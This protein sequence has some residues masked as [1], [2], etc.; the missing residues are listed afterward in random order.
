LPRW[1]HVPHRHTLPRGQVQWCWVGNLLQLQCGVLWLQLWADHLLLHGPVPSWD[2]WCGAWT[3]GAVVFRWLQSGVCVC[4]REH[5]RHSGALPSRVLQPWSRVCVHALCR[6]LV[7][8][9]VGG[10]L[11]VVQWKL[12]RGVRLRCGVHQQHRCPVLCRPVQLRGRWCVHCVPA[13]V[14]W[15]HPWP[16][17]LCMLWTVSGGHLWRKRRAHC[18]DVQWELHR[19]VCVRR[20]V[21]QCHRCHLPCREVQPRSIGCVH[22]LCTRSVRRHPGTGHR[23]VYSPVLARALRRACR[24]GIR[25]L[26]GSVLCRVCMPR[27]VADTHGHRV[28]CGAVQPLWGVGLRA[29]RRGKVWEQRRQ[30]RT[31]HSQLPSGLLLCGW[32]RGCGAVCPWALWSLHGPGERHVHGPLSRRVVLSS[33]RSEPAAVPC[34]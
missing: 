11:L 22:G 25:E 5:Q 3:V 10:R 32:L 12:Q 26:H 20:W 21:Y 33:W 19:G 8:V 27:W 16:D 29:V 18:I 4:C 2:L 31:L 13:R 30:H 34:R 1:V 24:R 6:W 23:C 9:H 7:W 15:D 17:Q 28:P 14:V